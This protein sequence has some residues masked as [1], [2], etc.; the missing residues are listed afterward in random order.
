MHAIK[1]R[2]NPAPVTPDREIITTRILDAPREVVWEAFTDPKQVVEWW[3]PRGF[4]T[5]IEEMDLRVGGR[6]NHTMHGPDGTD[7]PNRSVFTEIVKYERIAFSHDAGKE[8]ASGTG[9]EAT[10]TFESK[11]LQTV[12]TGRMVFP[13]AAARDLVVKEYGAIEG[14]RQTFDRLEEK[15]ERMPVVIDRVYDA[16]VNTV[17][18]ALTELDQM[19]QW[20]MPF[21]ESFEPRVG[22]ETRFSVKHEGKDFPHIW[23]ITEVQPEKKI[24]YT[25][26][27]PG[28]PGESLL[29]YELFPQGNKTRLRL[30]HA[31]LETHEG[32]KNTDLA[33]KNFQWGWNELDMALE[34]FLLGKSGAGV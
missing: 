3:G 20:Y 9:F 23:T 12:L 7:Y 33:R 32:R 16:P 15:L 14:A 29:T 24:S 25:W 18:R 5:T 11:G 10:W 6:W 2:N 17:W 28:F 22:F 26:K 4:T 19:K 1:E 21:L 31:G 27:F 13:S 8:G 30:T 34:K